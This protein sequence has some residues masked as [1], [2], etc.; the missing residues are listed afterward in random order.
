M[1]EKSIEARLGEMLR[2]QGCLYYKFVSPGNAGVP[3]RI[4]VCPDG[5]VWFVELK[6]PSGRLAAVQSVQQSRLKAHGANVARVW[7][8]E[9][10]ARFA[11]ERR[12]GG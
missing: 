2:A 8:M 5:E 12:T 1:T 4:V 7:S 11:R 3:D 9:D 10:A 6:R